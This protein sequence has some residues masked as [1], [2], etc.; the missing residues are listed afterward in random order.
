M[1]NRVLIL[2]AAFGEGHNAAARALAEAVDEVSP[3][4]AEVVDFFA[5]ANPGSTP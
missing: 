1:S 5:L 3:G 2:T 4:S